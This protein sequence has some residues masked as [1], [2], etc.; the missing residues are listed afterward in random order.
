MAEPRKEFR[1]RF[2]VKLSDDLLPTPLL[3]KAELE[4]LLLDALK[5]GEPGSAIVSLAVNDP[6]A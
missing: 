4:A 6:R 2:W 3:S 1:A 5:V